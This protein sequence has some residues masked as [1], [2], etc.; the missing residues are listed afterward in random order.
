[1]YISLSLSLFWMFE[2]V[3]VYMCLPACLRACLQLHFYFIILIAIPFL[4][5][6]HSSTL[7]HAIGIKRFNPALRS[8]RSN[9][10]WTNSNVRKIAIVQQFMIVCLFIRNRI[11]NIYILQSLK[12]R[13]GLFFYP[14][15]SAFYSLFWTRN[16]WIKIIA[17]TF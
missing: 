6:F 9:C 13:R 11:S 17:F 12:R 4:C 5:S 8:A 15:F 1:M 7:H 16:H 14:S 2:R 10:C 3:C